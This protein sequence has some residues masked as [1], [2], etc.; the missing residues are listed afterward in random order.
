MRVLDSFSLKGKTA[1]I[2]GGAGT[3]GRQIV[4]SLAEAGATVFMASR[5][6]E[7]LSKVAEEYRNEGYDVSAFELEQGEESSVLALKEK[8]LKRTDRLDVLVNNAVTRLLHASHA[9]Q[10]DERRTVITLWYSPDYA[11]LSET[12]Q[13]FYNMIKRET[14]D[15]WPQSAVDLLNTVRVKYEG[16]AEPLAWNRQRPSR[17]AK[18][19]E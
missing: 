9:N 2:T 13:A 14:T 5:N 6:V 8:I 1:L 7:K 4:S 16:E 11:G 15:N 10:S 17:G 19:T 18:K 3:Y 12:T